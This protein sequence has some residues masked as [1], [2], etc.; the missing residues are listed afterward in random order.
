MQRC[1][2]H[3]S[4]EERYAKLEI[5]YDSLE[6]KQK[7]CETANELINVYKISPQITVLPKNIENGEYIFEFH[8]DYD[9]KAGNFFEDLLKKLKITKCD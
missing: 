6:E 2:A 1:K 9:K 5:E 3:V 4:M 7:I 8:D